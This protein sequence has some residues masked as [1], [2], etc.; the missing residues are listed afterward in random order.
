MKINKNKLF[1]LKKALLALEE[2]STE[3][4]VMLVVDGDIEVGAEVFTNGDDGLVP[5][6]DGEYNYNGKVITVEGGVITAITE[7]TVEEE[8]PET[9]EVEVVNEEEAPV[10]EEITE[11]VAEVAEEIVEEVKDED[12]DVE[13][14]K[15]KIA[16]LE[17]L[18]EELKAKLE[19]PVAESV[20]EEMK[21][22]EKK[23]EKTKKM[24]YVAAMRKAREIK[25][26]KNNK[27]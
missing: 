5:A 14:L 10:E 6:T 24:D 1:K 23:N 27:E 8:T 12:T 20:E 18:I 11:E 13:A 4:G 25:E 16:E 3:E 22:E 7:K 9:E 19:E 17:A 2:I 26:N 21:R 15:S